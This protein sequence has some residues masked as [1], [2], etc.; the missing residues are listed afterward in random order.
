MAHQPNAHNTLKKR[1]PFFFAIEGQIAFFQRI[2][3]KQPAQ[4]SFLRVQRYYFIMRYATPASNQPL[5]LWKFNKTHNPRRLL[6]AKKQ[7]GRI[8]CK[9][10]R[11]STKESWPIRP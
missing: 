9:K 1:A 3:G 6:T 5:K 7:R 11:L 4:Y 2:D 10:Y 8:C